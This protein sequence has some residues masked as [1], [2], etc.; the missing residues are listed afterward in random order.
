MRL[1]RRKKSYTCYKTGDQQR[2]NQHLKHPHQQLSREGEEG[3]IMVGHL[4]APQAK[5]QDDACGE[6][7]R[8]AHTR[9][10][11]DKNVSQT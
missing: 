6:G 10:D 7:D 5:S 4:V 1:Y 2:K 9:S 8:W 3:H 11:F